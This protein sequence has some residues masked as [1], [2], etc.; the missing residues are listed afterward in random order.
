M[1]KENTFST[2]E[3]FIDS[4]VLHTRPIFVLNTIKYLQQ[5]DF[6]QINITMIQDQKKIYCSC[7]EK[8]LWLQIV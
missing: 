4:T 3:L 5:V 7:N 6:Q 1:E 8:Q 2:N